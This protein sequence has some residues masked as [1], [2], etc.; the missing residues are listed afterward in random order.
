MH[1]C[2]SAYPRGRRMGSELH[3]P[4]GSFLSPHLS[5]ATRVEVGCDRRL[6]VAELL[7]ARV[8]PA[9]KTR[10]EFGCRA[11]TCMVSLCAVC[12]GYGEVGLFVSELRDVRRRE[13]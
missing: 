10:R 7:M 8:S 6:I 2:M 13:L 12:D 5:L 1:D 9:L 4:R 3:K 11:N